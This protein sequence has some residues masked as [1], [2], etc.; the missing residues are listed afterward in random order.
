MQQN[1]KCRDNYAS[2]LPLTCGKLTVLLLEGLR[3][4]GCGINCIQQF[5]IFDS[6]F[7]AFLMDGQ[8]L[9]GLNIRYCLSS[10]P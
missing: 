2:V 1:E 10:A 7:Q 9:N 4:L 8:I 3:D 5:G 6:F